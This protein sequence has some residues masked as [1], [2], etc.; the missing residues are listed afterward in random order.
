M[1]KGKGVFYNEK[2]V[3][4]EGDWEKNSIWNAIYTY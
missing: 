1:R 4:I 3:W 2:G